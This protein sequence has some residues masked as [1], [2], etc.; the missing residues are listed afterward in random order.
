MVNN[1]GEFW[2]QSLED[3]N[4]VLDFTDSRKTK[5]TLAQIRKLR[6][7]TDLRSFERAQY[8]QKVRTQYGAPA[9]SE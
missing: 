6:Q 1:Q 8:I 3:D 5:L 4:S 9:S 2:Y 7:M